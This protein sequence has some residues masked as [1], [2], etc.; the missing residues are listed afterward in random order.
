MPSILVHDRF[1]LGAADETGSDPGDELLNSYRDEPARPVDVVAMARTAEIQP[2][3]AKRA[4]TVA[5]NPFVDRC[6][7]VTSTP[8]AG[9]SFKAPEPLPTPSLVQSRRRS[10]VTSMAPRAATSKPPDAQRRRPTLGMARQAPQPSAPVLRTPVV[11]AKD[12]VWARQHRDLKRQNLGLD[13]SACVEEEPTLDLSRSFKLSRSGID[14]TTA[15]LALDL[16]AG[17]ILVHLP[18]H[19]RRE[20]RD[21]E[22]STMML[23]TSMRRAGRTGEPSILPDVILP[24][25]PTSPDGLTL[26]REF[27]FASRRERAPR[28]P[29]AVQPKRPVVSAAFAAPVGGRSKALAASVGASSRGTGTDLRRSRREDATEPC[30]GRTASSS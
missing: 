15:A 17:P 13:L 2:P 19:S 29:V 4:R 30:V 9:T 26:P 8:R 5:E 25:P 3:P 22:R 11:V 6:A 20:E 16:P 24:P 27:A 12:D 23:S 14:L 10:V 28:E 18:H 7:L 1:P 21:I